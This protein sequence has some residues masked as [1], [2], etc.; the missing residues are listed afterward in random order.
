VSS[1]GQS[2]A[3]ST[4]PGPPG[5]TTPPT[6]NPT[7][8]TS[9]CQCAAIDAYLNGFHLASIASTRLSFT[10]NWSMTCTS[11]TGKGCSGLVKVLAPR[12][13]HFLSKDGKALPKGNRAVA[14]INCQGPCTKSVVGKSK[15]TWLGGPTP[16]QRAGKEM[17]LKIQLICIGANGVQK[18]GTIKTL[19][20]K[21]K[22]LGF[23]DYAKSDLNGDGVADGKQLGVS[24]A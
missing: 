19:T 14:K 23:V 24:A 11:G 18:P 13:I 12:G 8:T 4:V 21:F 2:D 20:I 10:V 9:P 6:T 5:G 17:K 22:Q 7:P 16:R 15:L 1:S 3:I